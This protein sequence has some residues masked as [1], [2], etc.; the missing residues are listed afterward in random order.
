MVYHNKLRLHKLWAFL[1]KDRQGEKM[2]EQFTKHATNTTKMV[3]NFSPKI[4]DCKTFS[5]NVSYDLPLLKL[6]NNLESAS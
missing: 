5:T 4:P 6:E 2:Y 1:T 3:F